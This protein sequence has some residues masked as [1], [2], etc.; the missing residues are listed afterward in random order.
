MMSKKKHFTESVIIIAEM[1]WL[2][3]EIKTIV[4]ILNWINYK[5]LENFSVFGIIVI[6]KW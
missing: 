6:G 1:Y 5:A 3:Y 4:I 2:Y